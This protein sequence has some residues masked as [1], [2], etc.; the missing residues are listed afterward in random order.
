MVVS[1]AAI[2]FISYPLI[3]RIRMRKV[4]YLSAAGAADVDEP[5]AT[6]L[7]KQRRA[8]TIEA[9][10]GV[11][12]AATALPVFVYIVVSFFVRHEES[13]AYLPK[14]IGIIGLF[15]F[16]PILLDSFTVARR[17]PWMDWVFEGSA[18]R[19]VARPMYLGIVVGLLAMLGALAAVGWVLG[20][21]DPVHLGP[22]PPM[23][24]IPDL[25]VFSPPTMPTLLPVPPV[26]TF[27]TIAPLP[28]L[29]VG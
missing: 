22:S 23:S 21:G 16:L 9:W 14:T 15:P 6:W 7:A 26:P 13:S 25:P 1:L 19:H 29:T 10:L 5:A 11:V 24:P 8:L 2:G 27:A 28:R 3:V 17:V 4:A 18:P 12:A 20:A